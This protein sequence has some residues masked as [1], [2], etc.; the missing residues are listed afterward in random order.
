MPAEWQLE[1]NKL[2]AITVPN[3]KLS[4]IVQI[5]LK[6]GRFSGAHRKKTTSRDEKIHHG[7]ICFYLFIVL[8]QRNCQSLQEDL[9]R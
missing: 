7:P 2:Y 3:R 4:K 5:K 8:N 6:M 9:P 1:Y